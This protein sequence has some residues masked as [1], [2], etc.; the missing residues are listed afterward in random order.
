MNARLSIALIPTMMV[1]LWLSGNAYEWSNLFRMV[2]FFSCFS[3]ILRGRAWMK[4]MQSK[5]IQVWLKFYFNPNKTKQI[6][7]NLHSWADWQLA[8]RSLFFWNRVFNYF[9]HYCQFSFVIFTKFFLFSI[10]SN[11]DRSLSVV[12]VALLSIEAF[13]VIGVVPYIRFSFF[14]IFFALNGAIGIFLFGLWLTLQFNIIKSQPLEYVQV[15]K[16][17]PAHNIRSFPNT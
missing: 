12:W 17:K 9:D 5:E 10:F 4:R 15:I 8:I 13:F 2:F 11:N 14:Y 16:I 1:V 6:A 3:K 7:W